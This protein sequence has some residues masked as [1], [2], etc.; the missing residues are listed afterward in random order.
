[1]ADQVW[2]YD[3]EG[4]GGSWANNII[5]VHDLGSIVIARMVYSRRWTTPQNY[6]FATMADASSQ[7]D[8]WG[9]WRVEP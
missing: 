9:Y 3:G 8:Y 5:E 6:C 1:M 2:I 4:L 7:L